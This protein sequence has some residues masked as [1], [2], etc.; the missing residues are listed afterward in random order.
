MKLV[1]VI[2]L[3]VIIGVCYAELSGTDD[4]AVETPQQKILEE[5]NKHLAQLGDLYQLE[6]QRL[7]QQIK[8][9]QVQQT[10]D[11]QE[12][13]ESE[14]L[15]EFNKHLAQLEDLYQLGRQRLVQ[16]I[17]DQQVQQTKDQQVQQTKSQ[18]Q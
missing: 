4:G 3:G 17:K 16:Q 8:D 7:V 2:A 5:F 13:H 1:S 12:P 11:R 18:K 9:R 15:E 10:K 14:I 6:R